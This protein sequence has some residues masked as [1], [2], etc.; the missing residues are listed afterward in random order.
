MSIRTHYAFAIGSNGCCDGDKTVVEIR[1]SKWPAFST[2]VCAQHTDWVSDLRHCHRCR[3]LFRRQDLTPPRRGTGPQA[4]GGW[5]YYCIHCEIF[6][7]WPRLRTWVLV[8]QS[9]R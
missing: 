5:V 6:N 1:G 2:A 9:E 4:M 3:F 7:R 8:D